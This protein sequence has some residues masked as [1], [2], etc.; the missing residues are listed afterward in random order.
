[1]A[2]HGKPI[3]NVPEL[4]QACVVVR[5]I[6]QSIGRYESTLGIGPW[7]IMDIDSSA[8]EEVTYHGRPAHHKF[9]LALTMA[10]PLQMELIQPVEGDS[11]FRD[12]LNERGEGLHH[13]GHIRVDS[14]KESIRSLAEAGFACIQSGYAAGGGYAYIDMVKALGVIVE[15]LELPKGMPTPGRE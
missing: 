11:I 4:Y 5:D 12:F 7:Q 10:G 15:L 2:E 13:L 14:L 6:E 3:I 1:M 8:L 9:R